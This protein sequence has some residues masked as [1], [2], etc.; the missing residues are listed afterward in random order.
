MAQ[1]V[2][3]RAQAEALLGEL[4]LL[5]LVAERPRRSGE[6]GVIAT[7]RR[8]CRSLD[9]DQQRVARLAAVVHHDVDGRVAS[10][11]VRA[12]ALG[13]V[14]AV[15]GPA[16]S[17]TSSPPPPSS[18]SSTSAAT[19]SRSCADDREVALDHAEHVARL[20]RAGHRH[21]LRAATVTAPWRAWR[22]V[23]VISRTSCVE[24]A[25]GLVHGERGQ[26]LHLRL[27]R[28]HRDPEPSSLGLGGAGGD[29]GDARPSRRRWAARR[30]RRRRSR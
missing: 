3:D 21:R 14:V 10:L 22:A 7:M 5:V 27:G 20:A 18:R 29:L 17:V 2:A 6:S 4:A 9:A 13:E 8:S 15:L 12:H 28:D 25:A 23:A 19:S 11:D 24:G 16:T 30:P 26:A 1:Q